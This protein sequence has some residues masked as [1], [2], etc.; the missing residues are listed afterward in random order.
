MLGVAPSDRVAVADAVGLRV[1]V[2]EADEETP[3][4]PPLPPVLVGDCVDAVDEAF[5][6]T[7][8]V[9]EGLAVGVTV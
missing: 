4:P 3:P 2:P 5:A 9:A 1:D 7:V 8:R 6:A